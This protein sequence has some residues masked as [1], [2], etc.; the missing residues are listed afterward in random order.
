[1]IKIISV[2]IFIALFPVALCAIGAAFVEWDLSLMNPGAWP[3]GGRLTISVWV[4]FCCLVGASFLW[5]NFPN[6]PTRR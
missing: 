4:G 5:R 1:M 6:E 2:L 3:K